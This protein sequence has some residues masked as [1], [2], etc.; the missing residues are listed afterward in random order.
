[1][2]D[3]LARKT[4]GGKAREDEEEK[5]LGQLRG[6][7][8]RE[9]RAEEPQRKMNSPKRTDGAESS[10]CLNALHPPSDTP[11]SCCPCSKCQ[12]SLR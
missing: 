12:R 3:R 7:E 6:R 2:G 11:H 1:M 8:E 5:P 9:P 10:H 4:G